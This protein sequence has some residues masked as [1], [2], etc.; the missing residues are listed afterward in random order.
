[1]N[2][3]LALGCAS[4]AGIGFLILGACTYLTVVYGHG[5]FEAGNFNCHHY[6]IEQDPVTGKA[7][8]HWEEIYE[9]TD[10]PPLLW[11]DTWFWG[12]DL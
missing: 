6:W 8:R 10:G 12:L 11:L 2:K 5:N 3:P 7:T 1:M 9:S 4:I